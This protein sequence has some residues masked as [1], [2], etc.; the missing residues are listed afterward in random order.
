[1]GAKGHEPLLAGYRPRLLPALVRRIE[2]GELSLQSL[3]DDVETL[4]IPEAT[5]RQI[6]PELRSLRNLNRPEDL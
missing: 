3:L 4:S 2:G 1:M 5:L 6:D